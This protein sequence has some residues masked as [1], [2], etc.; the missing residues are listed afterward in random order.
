MNLKLK[1][2]SSKYSET[3]LFGFVWL[4][5]FLSPFFLQ[6]E[7]GTFGWNRLFV[8]WWRFS[9]FFI[10]SLINH[11]I[12]IPYLFYK[13]KLFYFSG[14]AILLTILN[15][16]LSAIHEPQNQNLRMMNDR[17]NDEQLFNPDSRPL[18]PLQGRRD[19]MRNPPGLRPLRQNNQPGSLPPWINSMVIAI[20]V[21]GFDIGLRTTFKWNKLEKERELADKE[22]VKSE[23][24]F[25]RNQLSPHFFMNTLNNIHALIDINTEEAKESV[26]RLS[27]LMRHLLYDSERETILLNK[28]ISFIQSYIDLM[29]LRF[30]EKV[31]VNFD[32]NSI[33]PNISIPP[34]LF[35]SLIENA[36]KYG[37][38]YQQDSFIDIQLT[39]TE[40]S[41]I[42]NIKNSKTATRNRD[43]SSSGIGLENTRKRLDLLYSSNYKMDITETTDT[44]SVQLKLPL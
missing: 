21:L 34:L 36:F 43:E 42:F 12:L 33:A 1:L 3:I 6:S 7:N 20:L 19:P 4:L 23:L 30:T 41:L 25:L 2:L 14:V 5:F 10:F 22:R 24:A 13:R 9:P 15:I 44:F 40:N 38:S 29:K 11:F 35:T 31:K 37:V 18:P 16:S 28:E 27:K 17:F 8:V 32:V 26:L 39:T